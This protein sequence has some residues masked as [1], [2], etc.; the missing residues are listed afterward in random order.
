MEGSKARV[1]SKV[2]IGD[3]VSL[4]NCPRNK[5]QRKTPPVGKVVKIRRA[6][7]FSGI[8]VKVKIGFLDYIWVDSGFLSVI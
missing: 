3:Y 5:D 8:F 7:S 2:V 1:A 4:R 6:D